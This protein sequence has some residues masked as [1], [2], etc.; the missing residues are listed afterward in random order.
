[1]LNPT[2]VDVNLTGYITSGEHLEQDTLENLEIPMHLQ[3]VPTQHYEVDPLQTSVTRR[4]FPNPED[5]KHL[6]TA[7]KHTMFHTYDLPIGMHDFIHAYAGSA[8]FSD[9]YKYLDTGACVFK[10]KVLRKFQQEC[11]DFVIV[12]RLLF[13]LAYT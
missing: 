3:D 1:M 8:Y 5:I 10:G 11:S 13:K 9:I 6:T 2:P 4:H 7:L 12:S